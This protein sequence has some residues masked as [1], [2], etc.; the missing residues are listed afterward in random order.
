[1]TYAVHELSVLAAWADNF[2]NVAVN[3]EDGEGCGL[4]EDTPCRTI[5]GAVAVAKSG[6]VIQLDAVR[7]D[8]F[9][10]TYCEG[11]PVKIQRALTV[12]GHNGLPVIR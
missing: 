3:G 6:G 4:H 7:S 11:A 2:V 10:S 5:K 1:M 9:P 8:E 12:T